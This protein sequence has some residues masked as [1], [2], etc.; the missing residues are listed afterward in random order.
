M[1]FRSRDD[2]DEHVRVCSP[3]DEGH[4]GDDSGE[5]PWH[6]DP[7]VRSLATSLRLGP[8]VLAAPQPPVLETPPSPSSMAAPIGPATRAASL[9]VPYAATPDWLSTLSIE[10]SPTTLPE[11]P[12]ITPP[13]P[14]P[15]TANGSTPDWL[16]TLSLEHPPTTLPV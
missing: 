10:H 13:A 6:L 11:P 12:A 16:S 9:T 2:H 4:V 5:L 14:Q 3:L 8:P 1:L 15:A 7:A